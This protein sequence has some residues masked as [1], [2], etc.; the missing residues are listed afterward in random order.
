MLQTLPNDRFKQ[1]FAITVAGRRHFSEG[2]QT[3]WCVTYI[4]SMFM[5][6]VYNIVM[7]GDV[8]LNFSTMPDK[9]ERCS[10]CHGLSSKCS[11]F[12]LAVPQTSCLSGMFAC[13]FFPYI[14]PCLLVE[15]G[16]QQTQTAFSPSRVGCRGC[17]QVGAILPDLS[18]WALGSSACCLR[19][20]GRCFHLVGCRHHQVTRYQRPDKTR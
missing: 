16:A 19:Q 13:V 9:S 4:A 14:S 7:S 8:R 6:I 15:P 11:W 2:G 12:L 10:H 17:L 5:F 1:D 18:T 3:F 20:H